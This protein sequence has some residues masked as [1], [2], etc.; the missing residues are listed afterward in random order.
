[1]NFNTIKDLASL[2][3][4]SLINLVT[5]PHSFYE[6][7]ANRI[8]FYEWLQLYFSN[9][10]F[11]N[12]LNLLTNERF[13]VGKTFMDLCEQSIA[14]ENAFRL[15]NQIT[16]TFPRIQHF[17]I[18]LDHF[19]I[20]QTQIL[21]TVSTLRQMKRLEIYTSKFKNHYFEQD[22][23]NLS[24]FT[25][26]VKTYDETSVDGK[27]LTFLLSKMLNIDSLTIKNTFLTRDVIQALGCL[28]LDE[29]YL[30]NNTYESDEFL[31]LLY[32]PFL[33][34]FVISY[35]NDFDIYGDFLLDILFT[36]FEHGTITIE[37]FMFNL[38]I[39]RSVNCKNVANLKHLKNLIIN[40]EICNERSYENLC[41]FFSIIPTIISTCNITLVFVNPTNDFL[42]NNYDDSQTIRSFV[43]DCC[44]ELEM[45]CSNFSV[46]EKY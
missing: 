31:Y 6:I 41:S 11:A 46:E 14:G 35:D 30:H 23:S 9:R 25:F 2:D 38:P 43:Y 3:C 40:V 16:I 44:Y 1:M 32:S 39:C 8:S 45:K 33:K 15:L 37:N 20:D 18:D 22:F 17:K 28:R 19:K 36:F 10:K 12:D 21:T 29:M 42:D 27:S 26:S 5:N 4:P 13:H 34:T 24:T 7:Y